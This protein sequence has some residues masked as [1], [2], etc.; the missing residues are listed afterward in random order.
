MFELPL[1]D[2]TCEF[3][4]ETIKKIEKLERNNFE[5][6]NYRIK[7]WVIRDPFRGYHLGLVE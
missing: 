3:C 7:I 4:Q 6:N 5:N 1:Y 2:E